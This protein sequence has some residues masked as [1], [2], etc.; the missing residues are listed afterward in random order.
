MRLPRW[1]WVTA[2]LGLVILLLVAGSL[3][4]RFENRRGADQYWS[5]SASANAH[6]G[7]EVGFSGKVFIRGGFDSGW[8]AENLTAGAGFR[9]DP[10]T[11]DYAY[12]GDTLDIDEVTHRVSVT[13]GF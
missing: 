4:T 9:V 10:I 13:V 3:E 6:A 7:L 11:V 12:A 8:A 2:S 5:G 1:G